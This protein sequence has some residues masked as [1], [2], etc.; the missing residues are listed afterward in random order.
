MVI[1]VEFLDVQ[2]LSMASGLLAVHHLDL[3]ITLCLGHHA[4][5]T[6]NADASNGIT[7]AASRF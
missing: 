1:S 5:V 6:P 3:M 4:V 7:G 2:A